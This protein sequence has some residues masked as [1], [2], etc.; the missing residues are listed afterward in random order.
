MTLSLR[1][2]TSF[3]MTAATAI[4]IFDA[5]IDFLLLDGGV[6]QADGRQPAGSSLASW[7][8]SCLR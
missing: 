6:E 4:V 8:F 7:P 5:L 3:S 2:L 1:C